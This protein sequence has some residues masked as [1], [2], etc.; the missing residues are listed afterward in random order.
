[1][2]KLGKAMVKSRIVILIVAFILLIPT[3]IGYLN[4]RVNYDILSYLPKDIDTMKGQEM[5]LDEF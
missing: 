4:T 1:M 2:I 3:G 5:L